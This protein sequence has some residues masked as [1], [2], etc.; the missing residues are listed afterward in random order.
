MS[1]FTKEQ[2]TNLI[3]NTIINDNHTIEEFTG[4]SIQTTISKIGE[5]KHK[6]HLFYGYDSNRNSISTTRSLKTELMDV[7]YEAIKTYS[8]IK[9]NDISG[10]S[11]SELNE[12]MM[13]K[14]SGVKEIGNGKGIGRGAT[15]RCRNAL[16]TKTL[17]PTLHSKE[18][19][20]THKPREVCLEVEKR[21]SEHMNTKEVIELISRFISYRDEMYHSTKDKKYALKTYRSISGFMTEMQNVEDVDKAFELM[22]HNEWATFK[23][24]FMNGVKI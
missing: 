21:Y 6:L 17:K 3:E 15:V 18:D 10:N 9:A 2:L 11:F 5:L 24:S 16:V 1:S 19:T 7:W 20:K 14:K 22:E 8:L 12:L 23:L 13:K 4:G